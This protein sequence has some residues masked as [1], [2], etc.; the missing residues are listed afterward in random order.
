MRVQLIVLL[1][2]AGVNAEA[3]ERPL[4]PKCAVEAEV[5]SISDGKL[6]WNEGEF[7]RYFDVGILVMNVHPL[8]KSDELLVCAPLR[9]KT[10]TDIVRI[11]DWKNT[12]TTWVYKNQKAMAAHDHVTLRLTNSYVGDGSWPTIIEAELIEPGKNR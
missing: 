9:E 3:L 5:L 10:R 6:H 1:L 12:G 4:Q 7:Y 2:C 8:D 11:W